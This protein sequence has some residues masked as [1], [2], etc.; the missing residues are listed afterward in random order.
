MNDIETIR[1]WLDG[2]RGI[3]DFDAYAALDRLEAEVERLRAVLS[4]IRAET[5]NALFQSPAA[6]AP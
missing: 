1:A 4:A 2:Q 5:E 3:S 6:I